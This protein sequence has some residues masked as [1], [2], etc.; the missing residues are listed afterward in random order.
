MSDVT[1]ARRLTF[2]LAPRTPERRRSERLRR[3]VG[4]PLLL[5]GLA[6]VVVARDDVRAVAPWAGALSVMMAAL[7]LIGLLIVV[8]ARRDD[9]T[10]TL[11]V[12]GRDL[13][14]TTASPGASPATRR[15]PLTSVTTVVVLSSE[16][17]WTRQRRRKVEVTGVALELRDPNAAPLPLLTSRVAT[18]P[19]RTDRLR[20][21]ARQVAAFLNVPVLDQTEDEH[22]RRAVR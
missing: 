11:T 20:V 15:L 13:L 8:S 17:T 6:S 3:T 2:E 4:T 5:M 1:R 10:F 12:E 9:E 18:Q 19:G 14:I 7:G 22:G 16:W 21:C